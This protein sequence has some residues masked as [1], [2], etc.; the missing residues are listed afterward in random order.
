MTDQPMKTYCTERRPCEQCGAVSDCMLH[1][2]RWLCETCAPPFVPVN[3]PE[4]PKRGPG[5]PPIGPPMRRYT[6]L[7]T[8]A[9]VA[10][11]RRIGGTVS[12]GVRAALDRVG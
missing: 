3:L 11:A 9:Q 4:P 8:D 10:T 2:N 6:V 1:G 12:A 7:L 5:R